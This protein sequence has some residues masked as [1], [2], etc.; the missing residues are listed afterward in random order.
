V[1]SDFRQN[2]FN[3]ISDQTLPLLKSPHLKNF[4]ACCFLQFG[5][6][7]IAGGLALFLPDILNK[8][9]NAQSNKNV[10]DAGIC[11]ATVAGTARNCSHPRGVNHFCDSS[12]DESVFQESIFLGIA[13][14]LAYITTSIF[15]KPK[16][17][18]IIIGKGVNDSFIVSSLKIQSC[19]F[20]IDSFS[21]VHLRIIVKLHYRSLPRCGL[22]LRI[23]NALRY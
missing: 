17:I 12:I 3:S 5:I 16:I 8:L 2:V 15:M 9:A 19:A 10:K 14:T 21:I 6:F 1:Y 22:I 11:A 20:S 4:A 7:C 23:H 13:F 18:K